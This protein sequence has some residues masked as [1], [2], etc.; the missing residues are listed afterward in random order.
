MSDLMA[1][2]RSVAGTLHRASERTGHPLRA[3]TDREVHALPRMVSDTSVRL[4]EALDRQRAICSQLQGEFDRLRGDRRDLET[5]T[6]QEEERQSIMEAELELLSAA[7]MLERKRR[8]LI[9]RQT[10][11][12]RRE[13]ALAVESHRATT[14]D[15]HN[16]HATVKRIHRDLASRR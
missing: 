3:S 7:V 9:E 12:C 15:A 13:L 1:L 16:T 11:G 14:S 5:A 8:S 4:A 10:D 2:S 6:R